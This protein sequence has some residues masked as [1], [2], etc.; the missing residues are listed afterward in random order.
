MSNKVI[1]GIFD[2]EE[3]L[4]DSIKQ[5][6]AKDISIKEVYTPFPVHGL[7]HALG[8]ERTRLAIAAFFYG[9]IGCVAAISMTYYIMILDWPQNIGGKPSFAYY[10]NMPAFVPIIFEMTILFAAHLMVITYFFKSKLFPGQ[11]ASNPDVRT[12]DDKFLMEIESDDEKA[13]SSILKETGAT[14]ITV[15]DID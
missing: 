13:I 12:T 14:E 8:L 6:R 2:D 15:K 1:Y 3:V 4:L 10:L 11:K 9:V 5:V 7:D